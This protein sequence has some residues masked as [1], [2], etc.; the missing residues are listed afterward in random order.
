M[1]GM[2]VMD[3]E[4]R[5]A[6]AFKSLNE[7]WIEQ[8]YVVESKDEEL[9]GD[10]QG[11]IIDQ[12][13]HALFAVDDPEVVGC[14]ALI[15]MADGGFEVSKMAVAEASRGRGVGKALMRACIERARALGAPRLYLES[16]L[17]LTPALAL[18]RSFGFRDLEPEERPP[19]P[20]ARVE[21]WM[22]LRLDA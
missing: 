21:V 22:E 1:A 4:P 19:S 18:Y 16:G 3:F 20:Y 8:Y 17:A 9:L 7:A 15:P 12:G 6:A 5:F 14:C 13:G 10:P 2:R 11:R